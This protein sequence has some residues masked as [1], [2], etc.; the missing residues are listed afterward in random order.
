[1]TAALAAL[2]ALPLL[3]SVEIHNETPCVDSLRLG[4]RL[5]QVL[6]ARAAAD[7]AS[8][9]V[10]VSATSMN[11]KLTAVELKVDERSGR[12]VLD[13]L[14]RLSVADC[15][16]VDDLLALVLN[17]FLDELPREAWSPRRSL[18]VALH[19]AV[20]SEW[21]P[22]GGDLE[23]GATVDFGGATNALAMSLLGRG[24]APHDLGSGGFQDTSLLLGLGWL[25]GGASLRNRLELRGG[26]MLVSG[27][28]YATSMSTWLPWLEVADSVEWVLPSMRLGAEAALSPLRHE[29]VTNQRELSQ[30]LSIVRVGIVVSIP[31]WR[32]QL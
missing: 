16:Q 31:L 17:R 24:A 13:R 1:M 18:E 10:S 32:K 19:T 27:Y 8:L 14:Y 26:T 2:V 25:H 7:P 6:A 15:G 29:A 4:A 21:G 30:T 22:V 12:R 11:A 23:L 3:S 28:G 20:L 9:R 5:Q